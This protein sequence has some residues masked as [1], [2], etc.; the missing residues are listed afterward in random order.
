[1]LSRALWGENLY[2]DTDEAKSWSDSILCDSIPS[3]GHSATYQDTKW[4]ISKGD[5]KLACLACLFLSHGR[6]LWLPEDRWSVLGSVLGL[7]QFLRSFWKDK[8]SW[9][10]TNIPLADY[11]CSM[12]RKN[13]G[14]V[15]EWNAGAKTTSSRETEGLQSFKKS[16]KLHQMVWFLFQF[17]L[18]SLSID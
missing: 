15:S 10:Q 8:Q 12:P 14:N 16:N 11:F 1:M 4:R 5:S 9:R 17:N 7:F 2:R 3:G 13:L 18:L 6:T